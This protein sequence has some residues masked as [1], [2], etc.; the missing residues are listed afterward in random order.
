MEDA[1]GVRVHWYVCFIVVAVSHTCC[2]GLTRT[3]ARDGKDEVH[4]EASASESERLPQCAAAWTLFPRLL[5][6]PPLP[7]CS[8]RGVLRQSG[9]H[10]SRRRVL[11]AHAECFPM[12]GE[13]CELSYNLYTNTCKLI[14]DLIKL[15]MI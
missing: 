10:V 8:P 12:L 4:A 7:L 15:D 6:A 13:Y 1:S 2:L 14:R 9:H 3:L 5:I 11:F